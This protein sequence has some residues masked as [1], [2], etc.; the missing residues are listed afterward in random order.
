M[1]ERLNEFGVNYSVVLEND[2]EKVK[3][4]LEKL[5]NAKFF[6]NSK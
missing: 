6:E 1:V 5:E 4:R 2:F 3:P